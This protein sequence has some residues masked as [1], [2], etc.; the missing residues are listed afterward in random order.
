MYVSVVA[1]ICGQA[2]LFGAWRLIVYG[3]LFWLVCHLF[4]VLYEEPALQ[5]SFGAE[6]E[7]F[8]TN[9]PR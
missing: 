3:A 8:R 2:L 6:Y 4:V 9:V 5:R 7:A 1:V